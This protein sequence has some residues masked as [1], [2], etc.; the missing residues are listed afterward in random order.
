MD[1]KLSR[2]IDVLSALKS[3]FDG[4]SDYIKQTDH[5]KFMNLKKSMDQCDE[6][7]SRFTSISNSKSLSTRDYF[8]I[9]HIFSLMTTTIQSIYADLDFELPVGEEISK[10]RAYRLTD[11][12]NK[13]TGIYR[14]YIRD[15]G[16]QTGEIIDIAD[17][18][19]GIDNPT[20]LQSMWQKYPASI[21]LYVRQ[22]TK[23]LNEAYKTG[24]R[25]LVSRIFNILDQDKRFILE[26]REWLSPFLTFNC[27]PFG[28][29]MPDTLDHLLKRAAPDLKITTIGAFKPGKRGIILVTRQTHTSLVHLMPRGLDWGSGITKDDVFDTLGRFAPATWKWDIDI[30]DT[31]KTEEYLI[32]ERLGSDAWR[33][34]VPWKYPVAWIKRDV[35]I[36]KIKDRAFGRPEAYHRGIDNAIRISTRVSNLMQETARPTDVGLNV[37]KVTN[38]LLQHVKKDKGDIAER[39]GREEL[40]KIFE[41]SILEE[42]HPRVHLLDAL[43]YWTEWTRADFRKE[44]DVRLAKN[45]T[46][47]SE[48]GSNWDNVIE[49]LV[50]SILHDVVAALL[51][52]QKENIFQDL[53][54]KQHKLDVIKQFTR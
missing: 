20:E 25:D 28:D 18:E 27:V 17:S 44:L 46:K 3:Y 9:V 11:I 50:Q 29:P 35:L 13:I 51:K 23:L 14:I 52:T 12:F 2:T 39:L 48:I 32:L 53:F 47:L 36:Q 24:N 26:E 4:L 38:S 1:K 15:L 40:D 10:T 7:Q 43:L 5:T 37:L 31:D 41:T 19:L 6:Y 49:E 54:D 30:I 22:T 42:L 33:A 8:E 21:D 34:L 16:S 45:R